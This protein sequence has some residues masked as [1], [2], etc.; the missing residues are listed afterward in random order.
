[1][2]AGV[3]V[4]G[5]DIGK[6]EQVDDDLVIGHADRVFEV[7]FVA[8]VQLHIR[9]RRVAGLGRGTELNFSG[10]LA[11]ARVVVDPDERD[12]VRRLDHLPGGRAFDQEGRRRLMIQTGLQLAGQLYADPVRTDLLN[13]DDRM[14]DGAGA[15]IGRI[16]GPGW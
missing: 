15:G 4:A 9:G 13:I 3:D 6:A 8:D 10:L 7:H 14:R 16:R 1:M 5:L 12:G 11:A 2:P